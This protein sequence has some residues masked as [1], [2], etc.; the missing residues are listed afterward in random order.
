MVTESI[1]DW[2]NILPIDQR[3]KIMHVTNGYA[4]LPTAHLHLIYWD[5]MNLVIS[6]KIN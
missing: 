4:P 6:K 1:N 5:Y 3:Q 2:H